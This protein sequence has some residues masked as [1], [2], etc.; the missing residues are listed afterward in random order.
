MVSAVGRGLLQTQ[1]RQH[2]VRVPVDQGQEKPRGG[3]RHA[4]SLL[5]M[6]HR[7]HAEPELGGESLLG[8]GEPAP[9][10][11]DIDEGRRADVPFFDSQRA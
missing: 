4:A 11:A 2:I 9:N 3:L 7:R 1:R 5:P 6:P 8:Q 10:V